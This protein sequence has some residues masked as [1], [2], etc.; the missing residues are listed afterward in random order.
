VRLPPALP[1]SRNSRIVSPEIPAATTDL[2]PALSQK[3]PSPSKI[4]DP[5]PPIVNSMTLLLLF[6]SP[7]LSVVNPCEAPFWPEFSD[8]C[9]S[10]SRSH[11]S[12]ADWDC[13]VEHYSSEIDATCDSDDTDCDIT[14]TRYNAT[15]VLCT[16]SC[17]EVSPGLSLAVIIII[18]I[19][20]IG[21]LAGVITLFCCCCGTCNTP[22]VAATP[23]AYGYAPYIDPVA[24]QAYGA[25]PDCVNPSPYGGWN[26]PA[27]GDQR[28]GGPPAGQGESA[29]NQG[30]GP[31]QGLGESPYGPQGGQGTYAA[32]GQSTWNQG[33]QRPYQGLGESPYG[34]QGGQ[35]TYAAHGGYGGVSDN[36]YQGVGRQGQL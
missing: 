6:F 9:L 1:D 30:Q 8:E 3:M 28:Q 33:G 18:V 5:E 4:S 35:G 12:W 14:I 20:G 31:Y 23:I 13:S 15:H 26:I 11:C 10:Y 2:Q 7:T 19:V 21:L 17:V 34:P 16:G 22:G 24:V 25:P 27:Y 36:P 29:G 32:P